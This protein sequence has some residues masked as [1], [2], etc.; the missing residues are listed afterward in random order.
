MAKLLHSRH[1]CRACGQEGCAP[2]ID[3]GAHP[4]AHRLARSADERVETF[5]LALELCP[6][7]GL[8][9]IID[10]IPPERLYRD[11]NFCFSGWKSQP[12]IEDE[13]DQ[14]LIGTKSDRPPALIEIA[15]NDGLFLRTARDRGLTRLVGVEPNPHAVRIA[16][17]EGLVVENG[18][19]TPAY[20]AEL[21]ERHGRFD[22]V[23]ARQVIEHIPDLPGFLTAIAMLLAP[24]G[25]LMLDLPDSDFSFAQGDVS[26]VWEEHVSYF[27]EPVLHSLLARHGFVPRWSK[28]YPFSG[29]CLALTASRADHA[30]RAAPS[31]ATLADAITLA[32]NFPQ[33]AAR[34]GAALTAFLQNKRALGWRIALYGAGCRACG[35]VNFHRLHRLIDVVLDDQTERQG[36]FLPAPDGENLTIRPLSDLSPAHSWLVLLAVNNEHEAKVAA[37]LAALD[38]TLQPLSLLGP[39]PLGGD[40]D[41]LAALQAIR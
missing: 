12:H 3:F 8:V 26:S 21:V 6:A 32:R 41:I 17:Q 33:R 22:R 18:F 1:R 7:C 29:T 25:V 40:N 35:V 27:T 9:Q 10:P 13:L 20:A 19:L 37:K 28:R 31:T 30:A 24:G 15:C 2:L 14:L 4:I 34:Y 23:V 38:G 5:P 16:R 11:Y 36:L 39:A